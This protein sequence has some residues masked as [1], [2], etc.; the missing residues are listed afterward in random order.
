[1]PTTVI[2]TEEET[3]KEDANSPLAIPPVAEIDER[4]SEEISVETLAKTFAER[5]GSYSNESEFA[6]LADLETLMTFRFQDE[7]DAMVASTEVSD[8]YRGIT[9]QVVSINITSIDDDAGVA[10]V[11]VLTQREEAIGGPTNTE[12]RYET[13]VLELLKISGVWKVDDATWQS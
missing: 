2:V 4:T 8:M 6:N 13:L 5:F 11:S 3:T 9:T 1:V 7:L 12:V 10:T